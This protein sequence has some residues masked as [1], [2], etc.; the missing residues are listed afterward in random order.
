MENAPMR[1]PATIGVCFGRRLLMSVVATLLLVAF[2]A[3]P[4]RAQSDY[5]TRPIRLILG[6]AAGGGND[7]FARLVGAKASEILGQA[8]VVENRPGA[9]GR[10]SAEYVSNQP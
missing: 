4:A 1:S 5:P 8:V 3:A 2:A 7:I 9:G 10:L 6:F